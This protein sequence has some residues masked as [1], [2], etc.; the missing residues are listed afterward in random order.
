MK[1]AV[2]LDDQ[3]MVDADRVAREMDVSRSRLFSLA[4][5]SYLENFKRERILEQLNQVYTNETEPE[6][7]SVIRQ[8]KEKVGSSTI[9]ERW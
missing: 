1:I 2:S 3:L 9:R 5:E 4:L 8:M 7:K 6:Q